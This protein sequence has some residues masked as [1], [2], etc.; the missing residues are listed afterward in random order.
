[1]RTANILFGSLCSLFLILTCANND[2]NPFDR[3]NA[4]VSML[5]I[6][7][8]RVSDSG[9]V[10]T[11][12]KSIRIG[13]RIYLTEHIDSTLISVGSSPT[14][15]DTFIRCLSAKENGIDTLWYDIAFTKPGIYTA[16]AL[17]YVGKENRRAVATIH[18]ISRPGPNNKPEL[19]VTGNRNVVAIQIC[20]LFVTAADTDSQQTCDIEAI[21]VPL[22]ANFVNDTLT[23]ATSLADT[24]TYTVVF[25]ARDNGTPALSDTDLVV[26]TVSKTLLV[27]ERP[28]NLSL[29][30]KN[31]GAIML[32]WNKPARAD[33][34]CICLA[35]T[36]QNVYTTLDT[37]ADTLFKDTLTVGTWYYFL[38]AIN[39]VG[40]SL[41]SDTLAVNV[42]LVS[43]NH[44][45]VFEA[46]AP[47]VSYSI[48]E[49][50]AL[51]VPVK[52]TDPDGDLVTWSIVSNTLPRPATAAISHDTIVWQSL[53]G[54]SGN[55]SITIRA[56]DLKDSA[57]AI[58][59]IRVG[60]VN[61]AP[62]WKKK[63]MQV[64]VNE[65]QSYTLSLP[66]T[67]TDPDN[68]P[69]TFTLLSGAPTGDSVNAQK[70]YIYSSSYNDSGAYAV[71]IVA[72]DSVLSDTLFLNLRVVNVNRKPAITGARDTSISIGASIT[73]TVSATDPDADLVVLAATGV[74]AGATFNATTGI[75]A[76]TPAT[77]QTGP[78][79]VDFTA[80]DGTG[81]AIKS[82]TI[83]IS[84]NLK[85]VI[86]VDPVD[87]IVLAGQPAIFFIK[88]SGAGTITYQ[89]QR[90]GND[91]SGATKDTLSIAAISIADTGIYTCVTTND[92]G[93]TTSKLARLTI[94]YTVS[95]KGNENSGGTVP[96]GANYDFGATVTV[97]GNTGTLVRTGYTFTWW[98]T[99]A[100]GSGTNRAAGSMFTL[101]AGNV[102]LYAKWTLDTYTI[103]YSLD[104]GTNGT[105]PTTYN[106][107]TATIA[108][109]NPT[110]NGYTFVGWYENAGL[111]GSAISSIP[112]GST[113]D[114]IFWAKWV[115]ATYTITYNL[116]GGINN[117]NNPATCAVTSSTIMLA[118]PTK[119]GY[120]FAGWF[121]NDG[122]TGTG[123]TS[124]PAGST[125]DKVFW[126]K[127]TITGY[128]INFL[129][130]GGTNG[131]N[132]TTYTISSP[133]ITLLEPTKAGY[134]FAGWFDNSGF[135]GAE[136]TSI[137][138]GST[139]DKNLWAKWTPN[140]Y[141]V[142]FD[143]QGATTSA[144][145]SSK[146]V[147][148]PAT[149]VGTL[150]TPPLRT[151]YV[152]DKWYTEINGAGTVFIATTTVTQNITV[153]AKW[154]IKD[155]E[156]N[157]YTEVR[158]GNQVWMV[159]NLKTTKFNDGSAIPKITDDYTWGTLKTP[160]FC[161]YQN[162]TNSDTINLLGPLYNWYAVN[163]GKLTPAGW[164]VPSQDEWGVLQ[165][166][167]IANGYNYDGSI[168]GNKIAQS[169]A[170]KQNWLS[171][172]TEGSPGFNMSLNNRSN[173]NAV[174][175]PGRD[176]AG[177]FGDPIGM[178]GNWWTSTAGVE[179]ETAIFRAF[180]FAAIGFSG[181][182]GNSASCGYSVRLIRDY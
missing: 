139:G 65:A 55:Y 163:T 54:D 177:G 62:V 5:F 20:S 28:L 73:F 180:Y 53:S 95:Y 152:F 48:D 130:D 101:G 104:G 145:P 125:G 117:G 6:S 138:S 178:Y 131:S 120:G 80:T 176:D 81:T 160:G 49:G 179:E 13:I 140:S 156:G 150:P 58:V 173:F 148:T 69:L 122:L 181:G 39:S 159:E 78:F 124:I 134:T 76:W 14:Q 43:T 38:K 127:W 103:T 82:I 158:I 60:D 1:M 17:A 2:S 91:I 77:A 23:W 126:A 143:G 61:G 147:L 175:A 136:I 64:N 170:S 30:E 118:D 86:T 21:G 32:A 109:A 52:A 116:D 15:I 35:D 90:N 74:P 4:S 34:Y 174:P 128:S 41:S 19:F 154:E 72:S 105:N 84:N 87:K 56:K 119:N 45:P 167:L 51:R 36:K 37:V 31:G 182:G 94:Q 107:T 89:W 113:G 9:I 79:T 68:D 115:L 161:F 40:A 110:K 99:Q 57:D 157:V 44:P 172:T 25:I 129:L 151:G 10:D 29:I 67:V 70:Q 100:D 63:N 155:V 111:T 121:D 66:D 26:I 144:N 47:A 8:N 24:G 22:G 142:T 166:F 123:V 11:V 75:F 165:N 164:H 162:T 96:A 106:T 146:T 137:P 33:A 7:S 27:P 108:L 85:P 16:N 98:N 112:T 50:L 88:A 169:L 168:T 132:P 153:Y 12:G 102:T 3:E 135:N 97:A 93:R 133:T 59:A 171:S 114:K 141:V 92:G 149:T 18:I 46:D 71:R 83:T 42:V